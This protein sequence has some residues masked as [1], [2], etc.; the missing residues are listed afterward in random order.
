MPSQPTYIKYAKYAFAA[1]LVLAAIS[2][3]SI[4]QYLWAILYI[5]IAY[6]IATMEIH[7]TS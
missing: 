7:T 1:I 3:I 5:V 6:I 2:A 4:Q